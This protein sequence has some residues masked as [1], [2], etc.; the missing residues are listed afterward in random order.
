MQVFHTCGVP[1]SFGRISL[2]II[3]CTRKRRKALTK[4]VTAKRGRAKS[5]LRRVRIQA[6]IRGS[7]YGKARRGVSPRTPRALV[8]DPGGVPAISR[9]LSVAKPPDCCATNSDDPGRGR[10]TVPHTTIPLKE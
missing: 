3:G 6:V 5:H 2:P 4:S 10:R 9:W 8:P 1:P 7:F